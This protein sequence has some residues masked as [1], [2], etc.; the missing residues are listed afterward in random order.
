MRVVEVSA[1]T[2]DDA[3]SQGLQQL[4]LQKEDA[5]YEVIEEPSKGLLGF[6]TKPA[7]VL[8]KEKFN[9]EKFLKGFLIEFL[10]KFNVNFIIDVE[11][12]DTHINL[13][14]T[15]EDL[16]VLIGK[17]GKTLDSIQYITNLAVNRQS[18]EYV[19]VLIDVNN[20]RTKREETLIELA[21]KLA[22]KSIYRKRKVLLEPMNAMERRI[23]HSALNDHHKVKTYSE[24]EEPFRKVA[25][26]PK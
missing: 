7:K 4:G 1:K 9:A 20:Y 12:T 21:H 2:V 24:G 26:E 3:L 16:G 5:T 23:I 22:N 19:R 13:N 11:K 15:G 8:V 25:I 6:L 18:D 14:I 10:E 17:H